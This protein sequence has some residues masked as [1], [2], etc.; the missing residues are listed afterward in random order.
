MVSKEKLLRGVTTFAVNHV[1]P[2]IPDKAAKVLIITAVKAAQKQPAIADN[3]L[4]NPALAMIM[5]MQDGLYDAEA[6]LSVLRE[7]VAECGGLP[8]TIAPIPLIIKEERE[9]TFTAADIDA[10]SRYIM[11][12]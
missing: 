8:I 12:A 3:L 1:A 10:L 4:S 5:P 6:A 2:A 9:L 11:E 7:S